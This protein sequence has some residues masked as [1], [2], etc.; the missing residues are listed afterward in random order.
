MIKVIKY[1]T[2]KVSKCEKCG[3][4]FSYEE[5]DINDSYK[6]NTNIDATI[7]G[8]KY[9]DCP[10]CNTR[11]YLTKVRTPDFGAKGLREVLK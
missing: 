2:R 8:D 9:I 3:C 5:E 7:P 10:Q 4:E 6:E 11:V 1:G